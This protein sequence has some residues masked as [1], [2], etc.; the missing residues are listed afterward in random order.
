MVAKKKQ[1]KTH[2]SLLSETFYEEEKARIL[3]SQEYWDR[4]SER[5][6][7][8]YEAISHES[9]NLQECLRKVIPAFLKKNSHMETDAK[10]N[11]FRYL[12]YHVLELTDTI[13]GLVWDRYHEYSP[14][15]RVNDIKLAL[16]N[17]KWTPGGYTCK[18]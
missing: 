13:R 1:H 2:R 9:K 6:S 14:D 7:Q 4:G 11:K 15:I 17:W 18:W 8:R 12:P 5:A 16:E 3:T 10:G